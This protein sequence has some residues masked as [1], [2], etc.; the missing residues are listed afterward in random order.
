M[1]SPITREW[2]VNFRANFV[3]NSFEILQRLKKEGDPKFVAIVGWL[4]RWKKL[5]G[6]RQL[7]LCIEKPSGDI[8]SVLDFKAKFQKLIDDEGTG[9]L[10]DAIYNCDETGLHFK[11]FPV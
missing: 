8:H 4:D 3:E 7:G 1:V 2:D 6:V 10:G 5:Y 9:M 11:L